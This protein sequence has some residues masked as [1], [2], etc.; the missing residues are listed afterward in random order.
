MPRYTLNVV[1]SLIHQPAFLYVSIHV[2]FHSELDK[3]ILVCAQR[4][5]ELPRRGEHSRFCHAAC[6]DRF[7]WLLRGQLQRHVGLPYLFGRPCLSLMAVVWYNTTQ[8][9]SRQILS[10]Q[11]AR[12]SPPLLSFPLMESK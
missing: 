3:R 4:E 10:L 2:F 5:A 7:S 8:I 1:S 9:A 11:N 6:T 12:L